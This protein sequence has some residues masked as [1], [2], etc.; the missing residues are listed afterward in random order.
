VQGLGFSTPWLD[1]RE[2]EGL[3]AWLRLLCSLAGSSPA[4][5]SGGAPVGAFVAGGQVGKGIFVT[6]VGRQT[7]G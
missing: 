4:V 7:P 6:P 1:V 2:A 5:T 3:L